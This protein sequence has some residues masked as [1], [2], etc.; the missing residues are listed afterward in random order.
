M[1]LMWTFL[2]LPIVEIALF[3]LIGGE[4]GVWATLAL[5]V[6]AGVAG[7]ALIRQQG[8]R[9]ALD[10]QQSLNGLRDPLQPIAHRT[11][12]LIAGLLLIVP[13]FLTDALALL[14]LVPAVR[15][16]IL[17]RFSAGPSSMRF[18]YGFPH[19]SAASR[20]DGTID[21]EYVIHDDPYLPKDGADPSSGS[22]KKSGDGGKSG[23]T[24]H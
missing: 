4:I 15:R 11:L 10:L 13:G 24:R 23:W 17:G 7:V 1:R 8:T 9:A 16:L 6:L 3:V 12:L 21:G 18:S 20:D 22:D 5:V 14:L 19:G 2:L